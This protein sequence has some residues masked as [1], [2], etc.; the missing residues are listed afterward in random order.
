M[1]KYTEQFKLAVV[2]HYSS[3]AAGYK[4]VAKQH[5]IDHKIVKRWV[6]LHRIHGAAGLA[7]KF[8]H[9]S[10]EFRL[11]VLQ[12]MWNNQ[13]SYG[14]TATLFNIRSPG[15]LGIWERC[16]HSGGI[17]ALSPRPRGKPKKM[18]DPKNTEP[19]L[20]TDDEKR[21]RRITTFGIICLSELSNSTTIR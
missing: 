13:L 15:S 10:A 3:G 11:S 6:D 19:Q 7:K 9:Y 20:P 18:P 8:N 16:Y 17:D 14:E 21:T 1:T 4:T 12:H 5:G 2:E